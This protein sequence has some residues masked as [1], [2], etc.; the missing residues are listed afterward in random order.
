[1]NTIPTAILV[2]GAQTPFGGSLGLRGL[3]PSVKA[4]DRMCWGIRALNF[5]KLEGRR[6]LATVGGGIMYGEEGK[7]RRHYRTTNIRPQVRRFMRREECFTVDD[8]GS[9][10]V[11]RI[12]P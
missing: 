2:F 7:A 6:H 4:R 1:M 9:L 8:R 5:G 12:G 3:G 10:F 11:H